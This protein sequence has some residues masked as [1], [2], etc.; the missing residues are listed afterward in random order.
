MVH[1]LFDDWLYLDIEGRPA[2]CGQEE[3]TR[4]YKS[5]MKSVRAAFID[6]AVKHVTESLL[7]SAFASDHIVQHER[8]GPNVYQVIGALKTDI[9]RVHRYFKPVPI[10]SLVPY[11]V[12]LRAFLNGRG[13]LFKD[14]AVIF[15]DD[16]KTQAVLTIIEGARL[17]A[18]RR[19]SMRDTAY[20]VSEIQRHQKNYISQKEEG[21]APRDIAFIIVSNNR[22]W[23]EAFCDHGLLTKQDIIHVDHPCPVLEGLKN[24]KFAMHFALPEDILRQKRRKTVRGILKAVAV[25]MAVAGLGFGFWAL[26][27]GRQQDM[28]VRL[29]DA[30]QDHQRVFDELTVVDQKKFVSFLKGSAPVDYG[31]LYHDFVS[32]IPRGYLIQKFR[33]DRVDDTHWQFVGVIYP[34][35]ANV[36]ARYFERSGM[37]HNA[38]LEAVIV[39]GRWGQKIILKKESGH[40]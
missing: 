15:L 10:V 26:S 12:A 39:Q 6:C 19:I 13:L 30:R 25:S 36:I 32:S 28:A 8:M 1:V 4:L 20:M 14:K 24:A 22:E 18:P 5:R 21:V 23:L 33:M 16:L 34:E 37:F 3:T 31:R 38:F 11:P 29:A 27:M 40:E 17:T 35:Q 2:V 7:E 9:E